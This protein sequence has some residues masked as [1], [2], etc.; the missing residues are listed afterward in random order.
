MY[1][2]HLPCVLHVPH[3]LALLDFI[4]LYL[5]NFTHYEAL[6]YVFSPHHPVTS[7]LLGP[8]IL[9]STLCFKHPQS[10]TVFYYDHRIHFYPLLATWLSYGLDDRGQFS[11]DGQIFF[12]FSQRPDRLWGPPRLPSSGYRVLFEGIKRPRR[13]TDHSPRSCAEVNSVWSYSST[14]HACRHGAVLC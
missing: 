5:L 14:P 13:E 4:T 10:C 6:H 1:A 7:S 12:S 11:A 2:F 3:Y 8:N 9:L